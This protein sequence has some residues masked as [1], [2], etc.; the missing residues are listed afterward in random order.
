MPPGA[1]CAGASFDS[2]ASK[3]WNSQVRMDAL[4]QAE[5]SESSR[6]VALRYKQFRRW[7]LGYLF[8]ISGQQM[9]W[10]AEGWLIYELSGS[11]LLL[12]AHGL[13]QAVPAT[14]LALVGGAIADRVDQRRLLLTVLSI[15]MVFLGVLVSLAFTEMIQAWHVIASG[16]ALS[17]VGA[18]EQPARQSMFP[19]LVHRSAMTNAIGFNAM[20]HPATAIYSPVITGFVL[21]V[22]MDLTSSAMIAAGVVF[23]LAGLGI[24]IYAIF[25][26]LIDMPRV[27]R[28]TSTSVV[29]NMAQGLEYT[30]KNP[31]YGFLIGMTY[32]NMFFAMSIHV[33]FPVVAK[34]ILG[35]G[36]SGLGIMFTAQGIGRLLGAVW[37]GTLG[38]GYAQGRLVVAGSMALGGGVVLFGLSTWYPLTLVAL[39]ITGVGNSA[40]S[41][42]V[43]SALQLRVPDDLRGR[44][45]GL[46]SMTHTSIRPLGEMHF[47]AVAAAATAPFALVFGGGLVLAFV[48]LIAVP[49][50]AIRTLRVKATD[51]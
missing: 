34:D 18:F 4:S 25:L 3:N 42:S 35:L 44:V 17:A 24:V 21:A 46:W 50:R 37:V 1:T 33:L 23:T 9:L 19:H 12:G 16:F 6:F 26:F 49:S 2:K 7:W 51:S 8:S 22:V 30:W 15:Q 39:W 11:K 47:A 5:G 43:Q 10:V 32:F 40:F 28:A 29:R 45:M 38:S 13:A 14:L 31:P 36:P 27:Q 20:V 48:L 41:I